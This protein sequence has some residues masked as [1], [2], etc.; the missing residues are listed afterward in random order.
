MNESEW[1]WETDFTVAA[2]QGRNWEISGWFSLKKK[3][4]RK[5]TNKKEWP[6]YDRER[7]KKLLEGSACLRSSSPRRPR[8]SEEGSIWIREA[9]KQTAG[10][11][12]SLGGTFLSPESLSHHLHLLQPPRGATR[13]GGKVTNLMSRCECVASSLFI[14]FVSDGR[15]GKEDVSP[16][17]V[18]WRRPAVALKRNKKTNCI[19][20]LIW[21][22][23][24]SKV[25]LDERRSVKNKRSKFWPIACST[26][27]QPATAWGFLLVRSPSHHYLCCRE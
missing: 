14:Y 10:L 8:E 5:R 20:F 13:W 3:K 2:G 16:R 15:Q 22:V 18:L 4:K 9:T 11:A 7:D 26:A 6:A 19:S 21:T 27:R 25:R 24:H 12:L 17:L 23:L 1:E